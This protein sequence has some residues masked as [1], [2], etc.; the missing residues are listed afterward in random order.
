MGRMQEVLAHLTL[1]FDQAF[2]IKLA[3]T[4][5]SVVFI[6]FFRSSLLRIVKK[7]KVTP[8]KYFQ[9]KKTSYYIA[10]TFTIVTI[11]YQW[12]QSLSLFMTFLG[13]IAAALVIT[14]KEPF[15]SLAGWLFIIWRKPFAVG[16]RIQ[17]GNFKGDV[18]DTSIFRFIMIEVGAWVEADQSTGGII[19]VPNLKVFADP[20][21][22]YSQGFHYVWNELTIHLALDVDWERAKEV[23]QEV[24]A[25]KLP[26]L[27]KEATKAIDEAN[28]RYLMVYQNLAPIIYTKVTEKSLNLTLRYLCPPRQRRSSEHELW[29][30]ILTRFKK[31]DLKLHS[32]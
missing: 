10:N 26:N 15:L 12:T 27:E 31:A 32:L 11:A 5:V 19:H 20:I 23:L 3:I 1:Q 24:I 4:L 7:Q 2:F 6:W 18:I 28:E 25:A 21:I 22:N 30:E 14:W 16:D 17:I 9:W 29:E 8:Q 13:L